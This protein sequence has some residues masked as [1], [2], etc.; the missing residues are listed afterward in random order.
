MYEWNKTFLKILEIKHLYQEKFG[1]IPWDNYFP[2]KN[3]FHFIVNKLNIK[4]YTDWSL[5][6]S[7]SSYKN[8]L[9][10][11]YNLIVAAEEM[12]KNENSLNREARG[13]VIDLKNEQIVNC[14]FKKFFNVG[15]VPE[16]EWDKIVDKI[17]KASLFEI[18]DKLDGSMQSASFYEGEIVLAG[19]ESCNP[20]D[21]W[22]VSESYQYLDEHPNY[23]NMIANNPY[24][25]FIFESISPND[26]HVVVYEE[27]K[28]G[29]YLIGIRDKI[30]GIES[31]YKEILEI[32]NTYK[33]LST[34][35]ENHSLEE[36]LNLRSKFKAYE[37]E[38]WVLSIDG[39]KVK[40]KCE[41]FLNIHR[42][43]AKK[44]LSK[45]LI[46]SIENGT[47]DDVLSSIPTIYK[48]NALDMIEKIYQYIEKETKIINEYY[49]KAPKETKIEFINFVK[50]EVP[51]K[52]R[53]NVI[54]LYNNAPLYILRN[55]AGKFVK[56]DEIGLEKVLIINLQK[57]EES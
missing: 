27:N 32:A 44:S 7:I 50:N 21:S 41:D 2:E 47:I 33:V 23:K 9:L 52:Y 56:S 38:G 43:Y 28:Y 57:T 25:T 4:E 15:E 29:L 19:S 35:I 3:I 5:T 6:L 42:T 16:T 1:E 36:L 30:T 31:S 17:N 18:T 20:N 51:E 45:L 12:W 39:F 40:F 34:T 11:H 8:L 14:P 37:K 48:K 53:T 24:K 26:P 54:N 46:R 10:F 22:R 13:L 55:R 49:D